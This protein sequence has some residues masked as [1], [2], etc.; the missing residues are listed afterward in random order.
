VLIKGGRFE[1]DLVDLKKRS[2]YWSQAKEAECQRC[3]WFYKENN[4]QLY[5]PYDEEYCEFLEV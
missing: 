1:V 2:I 4:E 5:E 3:L